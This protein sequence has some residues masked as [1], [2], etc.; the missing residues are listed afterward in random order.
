MNI[1]CTV[2]EF[3]LIDHEEVPDMEIY[4]DLYEIFAGDDDYI[5]IE[6]ENDSSDDINEDNKKT[7]IKKYIPLRW[8]GMSEIYAFYKIF[9][10]NIN[11][12]VGVR[13]NKSKNKMDFV[14]MILKNL[15]KDIN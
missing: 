6:K 10:I 1:D 9:G 13:W 4:K 14:N 2:G 11:Q 5:L 15:I 3:V 12:Y 8:G 7:Y